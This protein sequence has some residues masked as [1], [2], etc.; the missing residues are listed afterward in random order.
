MKMND[1]VLTSILLL[2][3]FHVQL[4][5]KYVLARSFPRITCDRVVTV[6]GKYLAMTLVGEDTVLLRLATVDPG[7]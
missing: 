5:Y 7:Q 1:V 4:Q 2:A 6:G 3:L